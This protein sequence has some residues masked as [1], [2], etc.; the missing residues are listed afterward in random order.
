MLVAPAEYPPPVAPDA[1]FV[2]P[3]TDGGRR[4]A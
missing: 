1:E 2:G 4:W 3:P